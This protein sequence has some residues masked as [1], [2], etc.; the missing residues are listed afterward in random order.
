[1]SENPTFLNS[2]DE[3]G[4]QLNSNCCIIQTFHV[5]C[6]EIQEMRFK[7]VSSNEIAAKKP[8]KLQLLKLQSNNENHFFS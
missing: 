3:S 8:E 5:V 7:K 1:M 2:F 4:F 6:Y